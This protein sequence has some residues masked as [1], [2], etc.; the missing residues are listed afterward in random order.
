M[1]VEDQFKEKAMEW[2]LE[3]EE[4]AKRGGDFVAEKAPETVQQYVTY[5]FVESSVVAS[6][7]AVGVVLV[8]MVAAYFYK[9]GS[10]MCRA[11]DSLTRMEGAWICGLSVAFGTAGAGAMFCGVIVWV[12]HVVKIWLAPNVF[13]LE[14]LSRLVK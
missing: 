12:L 1:S 2:L 8:G 6:V 10:G 7:F 4:L 14:E 9:K 3:A 13:I 11:S 5:H